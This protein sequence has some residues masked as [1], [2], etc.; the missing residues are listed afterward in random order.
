MSFSVD[1]S[2]LDVLKKSQG[3][4]K[5]GRIQRYIDQEVIR[6]MALFTPFG[7]GALQNSAYGKNGEVIYTVPYSKFLYYGKVMVSTSTGSTWAR[8]GE[9]KV[10]ANRALTFKG[11]PMRGP[12][13]FLRMKAHYGREI[14]KGAG[15]QIGK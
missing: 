2:S 5:E 12:Y 9:E 3:L 14:L 13:W 1:L 8:A 4:G 7:T 15:R 6:R 10:V 11:A